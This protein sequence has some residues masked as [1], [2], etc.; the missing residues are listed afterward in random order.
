MIM[1][2]LIDNRDSA[3]NSGSVL[4]VNDICPDSSQTINFEALARYNEDLRRNRS[5]KRPACP[6][7]YHENELTPEVLAEIDDAVR[8]HD[9]TRAL[10][11]DR[12]EHGDYDTELIHATTFIL[13]Y[14]QINPQ[15]NNL[16]DRLN[17]RLLSGDILPQYA[18]SLRRPKMK[19]TGHGLYTLRF[20]PNGIN[21]CAAFVSLI[22]NV[23]PAEKA[24]SRCVKNGLGPFRFCMVSEGLFYGS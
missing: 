8:A 23:M 2:R 16:I 10:D 13:R 9:F 21:A 11:M 12:D 15:D 24:C 3:H 22:G 4:S 17:E 1:F 7:S 18:L 19:T 6:P 14:V 5:S 20:L